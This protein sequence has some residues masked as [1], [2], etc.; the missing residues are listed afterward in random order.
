MGSFGAELRRCRERRALSLRALAPIVRFDPGQL[1]KVETGARRPSRLLAEQCDKAL[2]AGGVLLQA[3]DAENGVTRPAQLPFEP[4]RFVGRDVE[5]RQLSAALHRGRQA[6]QA[7]VVA[8]DGPAGAGKTSLALVW[9]HR[10][11]AEFVDG[12][13][14]ADLHGFAPNEHDRA[15]PSK[16]LEAFCST[17]GAQQI[18]VDVGQRAA[19]F[20][21]LMAGRRM[22]ILLDNAADFA[23]VE[24]LLPGAPGCV[25]VVTS[26]RMLGGLRA[27]INA[28]VV[29]VG[30]LDEQHSIE[31]VTEL[32]GPERAE[33]EPDAVRQLVRLCGRL[34]LALSIA[35][36]RVASHRR[37]PITAL[38]DELCVEGRLLD[39]LAFEEASDDR[40]VMR[41]VLSWSYR[42]LSSEDADAFRKL[43]LHGGPTL[44]I[45]AA[46]ALVGLDEMATARA[47]RRLAGV[48]L[49]EFLSAERFHVH[50]LV[51]DYALERAQWED[52]PD[53]RAA[54]ASR[55]A[56]WYLARVCA[57]ATVM[58]PTRSALAEIKE[59]LSTVNRSFVD[60]MDA[61]EWCDAERD[62]FVPVVRMAADHGPIGTAWRLAMGLWDYFRWSRPWSVWMET[63]EIAL[64]SATDEGDVHGE[65][66]VATNLAEAYRL[67]HE[68]ERAQELCDRVMALHR[69]G[70]DDLGMAWI[71][72]RAACLAA[73]CDELHAARDYARAASESFLRL[74]HLE[75]QAVAQGTLGA[76]QRIRGRYPAARLHLTQALRLLEHI[77]NSFRR[78]HALSDLARVHLAQGDLDNA[79]IAAER[80][81]EELCRCRDLWSEAELMSVRGQ[82]LH[83][84]GRR[85][86]ANESW[87][88]AR[89]YFERIRD[90]AGVD[91]IARLRETLGAHGWSASNINDREQ[92]TCAV[93]PAVCG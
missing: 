89:E 29:T 2:D 16:L 65:G 63:H 83:L 78:G 67:Q 9:A 28:T 74:G 1:S 30:P 48:H 64:A 3:W 50:D 26:R 10:H 11:A 8:I 35:G 19:L 31:L 34:P 66:W 76:V 73:C 21:S 84:L 47:I 85:D 79:L 22:L 46:A 77:E 25:V 42:H 41:N 33:A 13:L 38:V 86:E 51:H 91:R 93:E 68:W 49:V 55:L 59:P 36:E 87:R 81:I 61:I 4:P 56:T 44:A 14:C 43:G 20:R 69:E 70:G 12:Q 71:L 72:A 23:Q 75:G 82:V 57:V 15:D 5:F 6:G 52:S 53:D 18:P 90:Q 7:T 88:L 92:R 60:E 37:L 17:L 27:R 32:I 39:G 80:G 58:A 45:E 54:A 40:L 62:N 24:P